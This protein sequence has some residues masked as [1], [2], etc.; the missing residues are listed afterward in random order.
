MVQISAP[1]VAPSCNA[2]AYNCP[3]CH[4][5]ANQ[6][7][8][9]LMRFIKHAN[10]GAI[11]GAR[12]GTCIHCHNFT[13]W[14]DQKMIYP[15]TSTA[16]FPNPDLPDDIKQDV[17]EARQIAT[18]SPRGAAAL[19]RLSIQKMCIFYAPKCQLGTSNQY[20]KAGV[21]PYLVNL[22]SPPFA[23]DNMR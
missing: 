14:L 19:L 20:V 6:A 2:N 15:L 23:V 1:Y 18:L 5:Y 21:M 11:E 9:D 22:P 7:W 12:L 3:H 10:H 4:A 16:P 8:G 13:I 17:E